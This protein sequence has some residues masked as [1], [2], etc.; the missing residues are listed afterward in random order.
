MICQWWDI[1][2][3]NIS[4]SWKRSEDRALFMT[5][6]PPFLIIV[7]EC[8]GFKEEPCGVAKLMKYCSK[9]MVQ[10]F[11]LVNKVLKKRL[12]ALSTSLRIKIF[13]ICK[14]HTGQYQFAIK[15]SLSAFLLFHYE[16][17]LGQYFH[18]SHLCLSSIFC[19]ISRKMKKKV[20]SIL[21]ID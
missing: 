11:I 15:S 19:M 6:I 16:K 12:H 9:V 17:D 10:C 20:S 14:K 18:L 5:S 3:P 1:L 7:K 8:I 4:K 13:K 2:N 21:L